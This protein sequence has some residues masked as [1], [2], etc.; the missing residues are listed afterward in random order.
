VD[1]DPPP[2]R[3]GA[4]DLTAALAGAAGVPTI[5]RAVERAYVHRGVKATGWPPTRWL[6]RLRPDPLDRLHLGE[7]AQGVTSVPAAAPAARAAVG[8][9]LREVADRSSAGL[10]A[11]W[12]EAILAAA[13][14]RTDDLTDA[15]DQA[16]RRTDLAAARRP[17]WWRVVGLVQWL[18]TLAA[19]VGLAWL[20][21]R[22]VLFALGL[23][24][25]LPEPQVGRVPWPTV[26]LAGGL[27]AGLL[28]SLVV[29]PVLAIAAGRRAARARTRLN[30]AVGGV[31]EELVVSPVTLAL[32][33]YALARGELR[34]AR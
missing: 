10:P 16:V 17:L 25:L 22:L 9:A 4:K 6:R 30:R 13:R 23:P 21:A 28:V 8:L 29:R 31:A 5:V 33:A 34:R 20:G 3:L 19:L 26:L 27:L 18:T 32:R 11:P 15:L 1:R 7:A 2:E 12:P 24:N 14:S